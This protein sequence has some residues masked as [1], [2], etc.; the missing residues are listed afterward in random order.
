MRLEDQVCSLELANKLKALGVKQ[1]SYFWWDTRHINLFTKENG[2]PFHS[3]DI[4]SAFTVTELGEYL[5]NL[6]SYEQFYTAYREAMALSADSDAVSSPAR[7]ACN[8]MVQP[9]IAASMLIY[10]LENN[11]VAV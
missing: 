6:L 4:V 10:L 2:Q 11:L 5:E 1:E 8:L 3:E 9:D 7:V